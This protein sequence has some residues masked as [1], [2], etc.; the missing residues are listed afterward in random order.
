MGIGLGGDNMS[1]FC[2]K[3]DLYDSL[4]MIQ[5]DND[6]EKLAEILKNLQLFVRGKD[7]RNHLVKSDTKKDIAKYYPYLTAIAAHSKNYHNIV[8]SSDSFIDQEEEERKQWIV[9]DILRYWNKHKKD[10]DE[11]DCLGS[12]CIWSDGEQYRIF[13]HYVGIYGDKADFSDIHLP[14]WEYYRLEWFKELCKLGYTER[15]AYDWVYKGMF[16]SPERIRKRIGRDLKN[17]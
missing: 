14:L 4:I 3:C 10:Y 2:G 9:R 6:D 11:D 15:E 16:D 12:L 5:S 13:A 1:R 17:D 8:L 7:G